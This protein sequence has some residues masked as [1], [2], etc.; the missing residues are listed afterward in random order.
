[1]MVPLALKKKIVARVLELAVL[2]TMGTHIYSFCGQLYLQESG[3]PIG[4]RFTA[5]LA[6]LIMKK[7]DKAWREVCEREGISYEL[8]IRYVDDCRMFCMAIG[9]GWAWEKG[10]FR[11]CWERWKKDMKEK[12]KEGEEHSDVERTT[13]ELTKAM[14]ALVP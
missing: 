5:S 3:G 9:E 12:E 6:N 14:S 4:L 2:V 13:R 10:G 11:F 8:Y 1:M 7:F